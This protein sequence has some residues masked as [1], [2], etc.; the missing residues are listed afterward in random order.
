MPRNLLVLPAA[1]AGLLLLAGCA[2]TGGG[3][4]PERLLPTPGFADGWVMETPVDIYDPD[5][6]FDYIDG[7][8][9]LYFPYGFE[10]LASGTYVGSGGD[11][12]TVD[13]Y[14]M[15]SPF[16][17]FGIY[18]NYRYA[19]VTTVPYGAEGHGDGYQVMFYKDR[20]F[21]R[22]SASGDPKE[23]GPVLA[24]CA[25]AV[26]D[27]LPGDDNPP[28]EAALLAIE[29]VNPATIK[30]IAESLLGYAFFSKGLLGEIDFGDQYVRV[31]IVMA[32]SEDAATA[33]FDKYAA[34]LREEGAEPVV[35]GRTVTAKDP[36]YKG[37]AV[38]Q[39][40]PYLLGVIGL[41]D[42]AEGLPVLER[43][44]ARVE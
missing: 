22:I 31:F 38:A 36:L 34:F 25:Q 42:S 27:R 35:Q 11:T 7:E 39:S 20:Y 23:N 2:T 41:A 19:D 9:E 24:A 21:V 17:A 6:V 12:V 13:L 3:T 28:A 14:A 37:A 1:A 5:T 40:G 26:A 32:A 29:G 43:L 8:A 4:A 18:S 10:T 33:A 44:R 15:G 16:D 30:Y